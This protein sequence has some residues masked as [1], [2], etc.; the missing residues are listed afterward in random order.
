MLKLALVSVFLKIPVIVLLCLLV[1]VTINA[2][3]VPVYRFSKPKPFSGPNIYNPYENFDTSVVFKRANFHAH[4]RLP[5]GVT[6][7]NIPIDSVVSAYKSYGYDVIGVSN[8]QTITKYD[9]REEYQIPVY[10]H[11]YNTQ[12]FHQMIFG[13]NTESLR[14]C[15]LPVT[16]S[17]CQAIISHFDKI[18]DAVCLNHP[19]FTMLFP[20]SR[21]KYL[22]GYRFIEADAG[23]SSAFEW[24]D[25]GLSS[26]V[27]SF[28]LSGD[29]SHNITQSH[30][31]ASHCAFIAS[32]T[33]KYNDVMKELKN[34]NFYS[35]RIPNFG[36]GDLV[37]KH[38]ENDKLPR[39]KDIGM[40]NDSVFIQLS[41]A[42]DSIKFIGQGGITKALVL[43]SNMGAYRFTADD[44]Y[45][46][47]EVVFDNG[48]KIYTNPA[49]RYNTDNP[50]GDEKVDV[51]LPL[52]ILANIFRV[53]ISLFF[54]YL[55]ALVVRSLFRWR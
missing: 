41:H 33:S 43:A 25:M 20:V 3:Q 39:V 18:S 32:V 22:R 37:V 23:M 51:N 47:A 6:N 15:S 36:N 14:D 12:K 45:I 17:A 28:I 1:V 31:I 54:L 35:M 34:G 48:V 46:R 19:R 55:I 9:P 4:S 44:S 42:A 10:E 24:W 13:R 8:Y 5:G 53:A 50:F 11:G 7:G 26:G 38:L 52:T 21:M 16:A 29:D 27:P 49:F 30:D 40:R 2:L